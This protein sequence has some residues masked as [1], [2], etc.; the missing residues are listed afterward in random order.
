MAWIVQPLEVAG[1]DGRPSGRWRLTATSDE[2]GGG[3]WG[4]NSHEPHASA[5]EAVACLDCRAYCNR[6]TGF[7]PLRPEASRE[8]LADLAR[9]ARHL[10]RSLQHRGPGYDWNADPEYFTLAIGTFL[11]RV[12]AAIGPELT[13]RPRQ[14]NHGAPGGRE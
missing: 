12:D 8:Q 5:A 4:D 1:A 3:P 9:Q 14:A 10:V 11:S 7:G 6:V 13:L 2:G